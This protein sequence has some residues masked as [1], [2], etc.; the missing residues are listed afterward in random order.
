MTVRT[1]LY[2]FILFWAALL[3]LPYTNISI[4]PELLPY[5][6]EYKEILDEHCREDQH[7]Y[8]NFRIEFKDELPGGEIGVTY[9]NPNRF[10][11]QVDRAYW[12]A[13]NS[14]KFR[15]SLMVHELQHG[16]FNEDHSDNPEDFMYY[17]DMIVNSKEVVKKQLA[18]HLEKLCG[19]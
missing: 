1:L 13:R 8:V 14:E 7:F 18:K 16:Y 12:N 11:I 17:T 19:R 5:Y 6:L 3:F 9:R 4:D 2:P 15:F 10:L